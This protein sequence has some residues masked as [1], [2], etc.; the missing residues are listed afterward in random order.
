M[1]GRY[2]VITLCGIV[3]CYCKFC[4]DAIIAGGKN[5]IHLLKLLFP[6][7]K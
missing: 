5:G 7:C 1:Q 3:V 4:T 2:R 6:A